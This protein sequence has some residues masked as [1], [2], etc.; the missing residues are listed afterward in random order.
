MRTFRRDGD[1]KPV[2]CSCHGVPVA[3]RDDDR[4][5]PV[6]VCAIDEEGIEQLTDELERLVPFD[7]EADR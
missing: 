3:W 7:D 2:R 5:L 4:G 6:A 1:D